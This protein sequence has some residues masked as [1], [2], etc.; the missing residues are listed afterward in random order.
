MEICANVVPALA[1]IHPGPRVVADR[2][3]DVVPQ[4]FAACHLYRESTPMD[5][6]DHAHLALR[7]EGDVLAPV[8]TSSDRREP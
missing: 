6:R 5:A 2:E 7:D 1:A 4:R 3:I 8:A